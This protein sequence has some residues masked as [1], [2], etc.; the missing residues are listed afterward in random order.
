MSKRDKK[1]WQMYRIVGGDNKFS[2][3]QDAKGMKNP[4][5]GNISVP[6]TEQESCQKSTFGSKQERKNIIPG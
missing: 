2:T 3:R 5:K 4:P 1:P 6:F